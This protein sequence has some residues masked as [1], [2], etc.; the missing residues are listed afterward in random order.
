MAETLAESERRLPAA[1]SGPGSGSGFTLAGG[2]PEERLR[3]LLE[4][5]PWLINYLADSGDPMPPASPQPPSSGGETE[6]PAAP[7]GSS[8]PGKGKGQGR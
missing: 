2:S 5:N 3:D 8:Q 6:P 7:P 1:S 4:A